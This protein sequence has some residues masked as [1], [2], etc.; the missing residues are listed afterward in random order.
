MSID[1]LHPVLTN[2][3]NEHPELSADML[4]KLGDVFGK[5]SAHLRNYDR[6]IEIL[7]HASEIA[8]EDY[9]KINYKLSKLNREL[10]EEVKKRTLE[11]ELL[12]QFPLVNPSPVFRA[13]SDGNIEFKNKAAALIKQ[14]EYNN[15]VYEIE[16]FIKLLL[17]ELKNAGQFQIKTNNKHLLFNYQFFLNN[18][19]VNLYGVDITTQIQLQQRAYEN[20]YRLNNFLESTESVHYIIYKNKFENNFFTSRWPL[21]YG[22]N[23]SKVSTPFELK[24]DYVILKSLTDYEKALS[25][26]EA[27]GYVKFQYQIQNP[28]TGKK[29]WLEE[30]VKKKFD[31]FLDDEVITGKIIDI[32]TTEQLRETAAES[33][34]RFKSITESMPV[35][36][37]VSDKNNKVIYSNSE[38]KKFFGKGLEDFEDYKE[39]VKLVHPDS[40]FMTGI[41]WK[42]HL[43][44]QKDAEQTFLIKGSDQK[45]HYILERA[46]PRFLLNG[47]FVG[48]IGAFFDLTKEYE[49]N[50]QLERDKKE[51]ELIALNSNDLVVITNAAGIISYLSPSVTRILGYKDDELSG[52]LI[53][54][55]LCENCSI[56]ATHAI[57]N[58]HKKGEQRQTLSFQ[59]MRKDERL[60]WMEAIVTT[61]TGNDKHSTE[62]IWHIRDI[63]EQ[64][65]AIETL[66]ASEM[67]YRS[68]FTNMSLGIMEVNN[69]EEIVYANESMEKISGYSIEDLMGRNAGSLFLGQK[70]T[71][72]QQTDI[73]KLREQGEAS[74]YELATV[75]KNGEPALWVISGAP[76]FDVD[77]TVK[78]SVGIHWDITDI[79]KMEQKLLEEQINREKAIFEATLQAEEDQR[80]QIGRDLHDGVGQMLAYMTLYM[81][82]IKA[83]GNYGN[84]ELEELQRTTKQTL[85]QVRTLSR[86]LAPPAIRDLGLR[87][88]VI[89]M[90][91]S[92]K[93]LKTPV[94]ELSIY[95]QKDDEKIV[96]GKKIVLYRVLQEL[97]NNTYKYA[98]ACKVHVTICIK[99]KQVHMAY[100]DNGKG[101]DKTKIKK[102]VGLESMRSRVKFH[103]GDLEINTSPGNGFK[104]LLKIP[105]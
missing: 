25:A 42:K 48:Y 6:D 50:L 11:V 30:E 26:L 5:I 66:K 34:A 3:I 47:E 88:A 53:Y 99:Q 27:N 33:E 12:S 70:K 8:N 75:R 89:E 84:E 96:M 73:R 83:R 37:W 24:K 92:Y 94:F 93:I 95:D 61:V 22:F 36:I 65:T 32:T 105:L 1:M 91:N 57:V 7:E 21:L 62:L 103:R 18:S 78:G 69:E 19:K 72:K 29:L 23:P 98:E 14:V 28:I 54:H 90:I 68:L 40:K 77:G 71:Q 20:F 87:D 51:L 55:L 44:E 45:Y 17:T 100:T 80:S 49:A 104:A 74:V 43:L 102:G 10:D 85:E 56:E 82:V 16:E 15:K 31:P 59:M 41:E 81:N 2:I 58:L 63:H 13:D 39:F 97:L 76:V 35:M 52:K 46:I 86:N 67:K 101:F 38:V 4:D 60:I 64:R 79:R 9:E